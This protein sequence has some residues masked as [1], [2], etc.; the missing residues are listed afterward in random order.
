M[1]SPSA[2][3]VARALSNWT[4][5]DAG[6]CDA[7]SRQLSCLRV[8][9]ETKPGR[10]L[11]RGDERREDRRRLEA[12]SVLEA[13]LHIARGA[14]GVSARPG[15][16]HLEGAARTGSASPRRRAAC[17][18]HHSAPAGTAPRRAGAGQQAR[19]R[20]RARRAARARRHAGRRTPHFFPRTTTT[21]ARPLAPPSTSPAQHV[22]RRRRQLAE[23]IRRTPL[24]RRR[25]G[26]VARLPP[27]APRALRGA[28]R[29]RRVQLEPR[30][31]AG[32]WSALDR[33]VGSKPHCCRSCHC[34]CAL[35][36][37]QATLL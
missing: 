9:G 31:A 12:A 24:Q 37:S 8:C 6:S 14:A 22:V 5:Q 36:P 2:P 1:V 7:V 32:E 10:R 34:C 20:C 35:A 28:L 16:R 19:Q 30:R 33:S 27:H 15:R 18:A 25:H 11:R 29:G 26:R 23:H 4:A 21:T 13:V 3:P 17:V